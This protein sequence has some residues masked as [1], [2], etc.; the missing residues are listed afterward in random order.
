MKRVLVVSALVVIVVGLAYAQTRPEK[1]APV[2]ARYQLVPATATY[3]GKDRQADGP[4]VFLLDTQSGS[5]WMYEFARVERKAPDGTVS[6]N[7]FPAYFTEVPVG[8]DAAIEQLV[9]NMRIRERLKENQKK[10]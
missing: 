9:Q 1:S 7:E 3:D 10:P 8:V 2:T 4:E 5:V 6:Q